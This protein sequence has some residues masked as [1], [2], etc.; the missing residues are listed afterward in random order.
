[1]YTVKRPKARRQLP[2]TPAHANVKPLA[3]HWFIYGL[4]THMVSL[5]AAG[6]KTVSEPKVA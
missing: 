6:I 4:A 2:K 3:A 1:M 5:W